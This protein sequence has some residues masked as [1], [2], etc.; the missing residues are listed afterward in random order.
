[1]K[2]DFYKRFVIISLI[3][4]LII[5]IFSSYSFLKKEPNSL[6]Y[7]QFTYYE[8]ALL[9]SNHLFGKNFNIQSCVGQANG[10]RPP[11]YPFI[12]SFVFL[13]E[14]AS[15]DSTKIANYL[16]LFVL[17]FSLFGI[18]SVLK[19]KI[20]SPYL[21]MLSSLTCLFL[22]LNYTDFAT[23]SL[24]ALS[25]YFL[26]K[27]DYFKSKRYSFL[28]GLTFGLGQLTRIYFFT[29]LI[30]PL[31]YV[32]YLKRFKN[33]L[34][35]CLSL[36]I[37][38]GVSF[39][40]YLKNFKYIFSDYFSSAVVASK[41]IYYKKGLLN[42]LM[43]YIKT[44]W[45]STPFLL[46]LFGISLIY[47]GI[48]YKKLKQYHKLMVWSFFGPLMIYTFL[49]TKTVR[50]ILPLLVPAV[51]LI[52]FFLSDLLKKRKFVATVI[53]FLLASI[54]IVHFY[55]SLTLFHDD[56]IT[57]KNDLNTL[58]VN[59]S[60]Y[61]LGDESAS[62]ITFSLLNDRYLHKNKFNKILC[63]ST[64]NKLNELPNGENFVLWLPWSIN[65]SK[66][67]IPGYLFD[68]EKIYYQELKYFKSLPKVKINDF[69]IKG[70]NL[71]LY[72]LS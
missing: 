18:E 20:F 56:F 29:F 12:S 41:Y 9:F 7:D 37:T 17:L 42:F 28:F 71:S 40:W 44:L 6:F 65:M 63:S 69:N 31:L 47:Y 21:I 38:F 8:M 57:L 3:A 45:H 58:P 36:I 61:L 13:F 60:I 72:E 46:I 5:S 54:F 26:F 32:L 33:I 52:S 23:M 30:F 49:T 24:F 53:L 39:W 35:I 16:F 62:H 10:Y 48:Y 59:S 51:L 11:F 25:L 14:E 19:K 34:N 27:S 55:S 15:E 4:L 66:G 70:H 43:Y 50:F 68:K 22:I 67:V 64:Y 1:M 2:K